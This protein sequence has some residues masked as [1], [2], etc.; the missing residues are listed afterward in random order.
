MVKEV[1]FSITSEIIDRNIPYSN[2]DD[3][4]L[5]IGHLKDNGTI[6]NIIPRIPLPT[7][8]FAK[9]KLFL[10]FCNIDFDN[11]LIDR[12]K[13]GETDLDYCMKDEDQ[14][15]DKIYEFD[16]SRV[17]I[18]PRKV[19]NTQGTSEI[20]VELYTYEANINTDYG[21]KRLSVPY[22]IT[23]DTKYEYDK[24]TDGIYK[25]LLID[26]EEWVND[27]T[28]G[29]GDI[30]SHNDALLVSTIDNNTYD[31]TDIEWETA[32]I[33]PTDDDIFTFNYGT[34]SNTPT[35]AIEFDVLISRYAKYGI[36]KDILLST[37][38][39]SYDDEKSYELV[40]L[41]QNL[42]EKAKFQ[43]QA[44]NPIDALYSLQM[45]KLASSVSTDTTKV[46]YHNIKYTI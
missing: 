46:R 1:E 24:S 44:H 10:Y 2:S 21:S 23:S 38:F 29:I 6:L 18:I 14:F 22:T 30:V 7:E 32:W 4:P 35:R 45:L 28:Y 17:L 13:I 39:K 36:I 8:I 3:Q 15:T 16:L 34:T 33:E 20:T 26:F 5:V 12:I 25:L 27:R 19:Y 41:L 43:L 42:R 40:A 31:D 37:G 11:K 9:R